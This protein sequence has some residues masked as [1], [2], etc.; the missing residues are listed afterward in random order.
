MTETY[1]GVTN[2]QKELLPTVTCLRNEP[3][4]GYKLLDVCKTLLSIQGQGVQN[5]GDGL[6][7]EQ[8]FAAAFMKA[9]TTTR[10]IDH[11]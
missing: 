10:T 1:D 8:Q 4:I 11:V 2:L 6:S 7:A 9:S 3:E 5:R